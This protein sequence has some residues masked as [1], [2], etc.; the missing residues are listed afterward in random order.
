MSSKVFNPFDFIK[1]PVNEEDEKWWVCPICEGKMTTPPSLYKY[2][3]KSYK[4]PSCKI[5]V[6]TPYASPREALKAAY[7]ARGLC[8]WF[9]ELQDEDGV[10]MPGWN[11]SR[12]S[13]NKEK[14]DEQ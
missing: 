5:I 10:E 4:C 1:R 9:K 12:F 14:E 2:E 11:E 8:E 7:L 3:G 13:I 6:T